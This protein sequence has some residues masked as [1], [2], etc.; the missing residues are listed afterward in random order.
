MAIKQVSTA[1]TFEHW[2][3]A[4]QQLIAV[5]NTLTD[6]NG[7]TFVANTILEISGTGSRLNVKTSAEISNVFSNNI[8]IKQN[9][10]ANVIYANSIVFPDGTTLGSQTSSDIIVTLNT[11]G[12]TLNVV[13]DTTSIN[14]V[15]PLMALSANGIPTR[16]YASSTKLYYNVST[17]QINSTNFNSLS[18]LNAKKD[19]ETIKNALE[20]LLQLRGVTFKWK[21]NDAKSIG[22]I[23]Q[24]VEQYLPEVVSTG[25]NGEKSV[26]Y[27]SIVGLV[28]EAI[29]ELNGRV[30]KLENY[31]N[32]ENN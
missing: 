11:Y 1:N 6:G 18:D 30:I 4:T 25:E 7:A 13:D 27:G 12:N 20:T 23:A 8:T 31:I 29:K 2:L 26:S 3:T 22:V 9:T 10:V 28:I 19:I 32:K 21:D 24:E 15:Y 14:T 16:I 5:A 17:G